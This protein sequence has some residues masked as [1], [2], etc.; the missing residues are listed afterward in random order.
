MVVAVSLI[1]FTKSNH[2][3]LFSSNLHNFLH[4]ISIIIS[5]PIGSIR[6]IL[7][8]SLLLFFQHL[9]LVRCQHDTRSQLFLFIVSNYFH[10]LFTLTSRISCMTPRS[11][12]A[13][14]FTQPESSHFLVIFFLAILFQFTKSNDVLLLFCSNFHNPLHDIL[15]IISS[16][17]CS[18]RTISL[19]PLLLSS[20]HPRK[21]R[22]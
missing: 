6:T 2:F 21:I 3:L 12:L 13:S 5:Y 8:P 4:D 7:I 1:L 22:L 9:L 14:L 16:P 18:T 11:S 19:F 10:L 20:C 15:I 17:I